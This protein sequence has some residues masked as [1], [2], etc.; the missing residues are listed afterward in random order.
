MGEN[1]GLELVIGLILYHLIK[2]KQHNF[3]QFFNLCVSVM[4]MAICF[5][6]HPLVQWLSILPA[7]ENLLGNLKNIKMHELTI[8]INTYM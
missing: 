6:I 7:Y 1:L 5:K 3:G 4:R 2:T 8:I